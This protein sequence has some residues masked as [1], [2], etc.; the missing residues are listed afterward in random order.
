MITAR[1]SVIYSIVI[2]EE[3]LVYEAKTRKSAEVFRTYPRIR[4]RKRLR[5]E[6]GATV[7]KIYYLAKEQK[8]ELVQLNLSYRIK[9]TELS[10][11]RNCGEISVIEWD[12]VLAKQIQVLIHNMLVW[13][14]NTDS[15]ARRRSQ[16]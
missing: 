16:F 6:T 2:C 4:N 5:R 3:F 8:S 12:Y 15:N 10:D 1:S 11:N 13:W 7:V 14:R 9:K